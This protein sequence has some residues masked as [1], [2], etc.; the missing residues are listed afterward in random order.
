MQTSHVRDWMYKHTMT[1]AYLRGELGPTICSNA[2]RTLNHNRSSNQ[3]QMVG[4]YSET[5]GFPNF[6]LCFRP[7]NNQGEPNP[8]PSSHRMFYWF[9]LPPAFPTNISNRGRPGIFNLHNLPCLWISVKCKRECLIPLLK[10]P[11]PKQLLLLFLWVVFIY[12]HTW[13]IEF[14]TPTPLWKRG[15]MLL[16]WGKWSKGKCTYL[17]K[18]SAPKSDYAA[19]IWIC[20]VSFQSLYS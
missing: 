8:L 2:S 16:L 6:Y 10:Q 4:T 9:S 5:A 18:G 14:T 17:A 11:L 7:R 1:T 20:T 15:I 3:S 19:V 12:F 13:N